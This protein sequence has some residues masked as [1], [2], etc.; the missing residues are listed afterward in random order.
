MARVRSS[1]ERAAALDEPREHL[2][3]VADD[4]LGL[5][6]IEARGG[7]VAARARVGVPRRARFSYI[8]VSVMSDI[9]PEHIAHA[10]F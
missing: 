2:E 6:G 8:P 7:E 9:A 1:V 10:V 3:H 4:V 5:L